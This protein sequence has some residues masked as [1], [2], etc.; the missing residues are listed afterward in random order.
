M[1][2][3]WKTEIWDGEVEYHTYKQRGWLGIGGKEHP[4]FKAMVQRIFSESKYISDYKLYVVGG[5]LEEWVSWDIDFALIGDYDPIKIKE[6]FE[7]ITK[8]SFEMRIFSDCHYQKELWPVH[9]YCKYGGYEEI[10]ECYRLSNVFAR[11]GEYQDLSDFEY[12]DGL[13]KQVIQY[14][15]PKH[16]KRREEGYQYNPPLLLN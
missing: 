7:T 16:I 12:V 14:P 10:H 2:K 9:L 4:M 3:D 5:T 15:F 1:H 11:N 6:V 8:I 13:Y